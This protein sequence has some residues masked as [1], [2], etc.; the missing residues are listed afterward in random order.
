MKNKKTIIPCLFLVL[1]SSIAVPVHASDKEF[2]SN[3]DIL[4]YDPDAISACSS[5]GGVTDTTA[6]SGGKSTAVYSLSQVVTFASQS[7]SAT[8]N[9]SDSTVE[10]WFLKQSGARPV[11]TRY[12]LNSSNIGQIT[13]AVKAA[14]VSATYFY[15]YTVNEG[16]GAA[17]FINH[18]GSEGPGGGTGNATRDAEYLVT[19]SKVTDGHPAT[20]NGEPL[21]MPTAEAQKVLNALPS[22][23]VGKVYIQATSA[24]TAE[25]ED[26]SGKTGKWSTLFGK[27]LTDAMK[28]IKSMGGNPLEGGSSLTADGCVTGV[29]GEGMTKGINWAKMIA[30]NDG[31]GYEQNTRTTGWTKWQSDPNCTTSCGSFDCSSLVSA[32]LTV[33]GYYS[34]NPNFSTATEEASLQSAGFTKVASSARSSANLKPGDVLHTTGHTEMYI[35]DNQLVGASM[36]E[37]G[38]LN[39]GQTGDQTGKEVRITTFYDD[40]WDGVWRASK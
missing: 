10:Q 37:F 22:G 4:F 2:Y 29:V 26:L 24:A 34:T 8:W 36:N 7:V 27:P 38:G 18:Y 23:S 3:N 25:I 28:N 14:G 39:G 19:W 17:G 40:S 15:A 5:A 1:F 32:I 33:A 20:G 30:N 11:I 9:L 13:A 31:Y 35:G 16:G 6:I 21:E 12:G